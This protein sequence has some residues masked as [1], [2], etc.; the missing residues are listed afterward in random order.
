VE[1]GVAVYAVPRR[2][3]DAEQRLGSRRSGPGTRRNGVV[4]LSGD[5]SAERQDQHL[6]WTKEWR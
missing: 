6:V 2:L 3:T 5:K 1:Q 4:S